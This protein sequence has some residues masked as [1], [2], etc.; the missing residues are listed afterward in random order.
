MRQ[1]VARVLLLLVMPALTMLLWLHG[2]ESSPVRASV[3]VASAANTLSDT[4]RL[5]VIG[6]FGY[7]GQPE[8]DVAALVRGWDPELVIT[9]G[10]NNYETGSAKT[11]DANIGQYYHSFIYPY[12][13]N[14]GQGA[15]RNRFFPTLGNHDW[16]TPGAQP[17]L[18]YFT[19]PGNE[20][21][22]DFT[23]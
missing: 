17:H 8:S 12:F 19:L 14:Y 11:I 13:G 15:D 2:S 5:A 6:D 18:D 16:E 1:T 4:V 20:R 7:A 9:I 23:W 22:Y 3:P 10:D 21:Y